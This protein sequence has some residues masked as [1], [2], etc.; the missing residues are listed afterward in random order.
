[1]TLQSWYAL[2][3]KS[4]HEFVVSQELSRKGIDNFLPAVTRVQ[5]WKDRKK[6][7]DFPLFPGYVFVH[8]VPA[9]GEFLNV[10]KTRG[11]VSFVSLEPGHPT[12]VSPDEIS[13]LR[14]MLE[15]GGPI[16]VFPSLREGTSV[17]VKRGP[18]LGAVGVLAQREDHHMFIVNI[19][20]LGRSVGLKIHAEDVEQA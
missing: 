15:S 16:D 8:L 12:A 7:V 4:R 20:I 13:S 19:D 6:M 10:V 14:V 18:M 2:R 5:Q 1:L 9:P 11:S 17:R 3:V